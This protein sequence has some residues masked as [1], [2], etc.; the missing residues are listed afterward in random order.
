MTQALIAGAAPAVETRRTAVWVASL[1][2]AGVLLQRISVP[3][4]VVPLLLPLTY[5]WVGYGLATGILELDR[6]RVRLLLLA[7][8]VTAGMTLVQSVVVVQPLISVTSWGLF[9]AV[10]APAALRLVDRGRDALRSALVYVVAIGR[11]LAGACVAMMLLQVAGV[12]YVDYLASVVPP[13]LRLQGY[14]ITYPLDYLSSVYRANAWIGLEPSIVSLQIGVCLVVA[15]LLRSGVPT[16]L[17]LAA[18]LASTMSGSGF[19]VV[20]VGVV[21]MAITPIRRRVW[22]QGLWAAAGLVALLMTPF[23]QTMLMRIG[24]VGV[25]GSSTSLRAVEPYRL[26]WPQWASDAVSVVVGRGPG[27]SQAIIESTNVS[28]LLVPSPIKVFFDYGLIGGVLL[29]AYLLFCYLGGPS[30]SLAVGLLVSSWLLQPGTTT[31][32]LVLPTLLLITW[33]APRTSAT[34]EAEPLVPLGPGP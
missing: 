14:V 11:W 24:E 6:L 8:A 5:V 31:V 30:T 28:G 32:V 25:E 16:L 13:T 15:L 4:G 10:W 12:R 29:A 3:G 20:L 18:G 19:V 26:L 9:M 27:A 17:L 1:F 33:W 7:A 23:G 22:R 2:A 21:V 34:V